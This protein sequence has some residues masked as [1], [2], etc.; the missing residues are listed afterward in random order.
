M[1]FNKDFVQNA[2]WRKYKNEQKKYIEKA[3]PLR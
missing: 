2:S 3:L 1:L